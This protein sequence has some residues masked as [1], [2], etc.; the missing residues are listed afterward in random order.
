MLL[1]T[2]IAA[3][4]VKTQIKQPVINEEKLLGN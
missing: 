2:I 4:I 1:L 3:F